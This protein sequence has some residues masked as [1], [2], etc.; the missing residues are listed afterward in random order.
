MSV[1][2]KR[3]LEGLLKRNGWRVSSRDV[4]PA[5]WW[6]DEQWVL[7]SEWSPVGT[8]ATAS[9]LVDPQAPHERKP[10]EHVWAVAVTRKPPSERAE[11]EPAF[12]LRPHWERILEGL[13]EQIQALRE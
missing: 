5:Q 6:L 13:R 2:Q 7:E 3:D 8:T 12:P 1:S 4:R 11:A 10:G 9:F